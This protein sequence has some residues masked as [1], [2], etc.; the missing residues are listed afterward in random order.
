MYE[1]HLILLIYFRLTLF[2]LFV[3]SL[4]FLAKYIL[5]L[6][7]QK[8]ADRAW[9]QFENARLIFHEPS[10][11]RAYFVPLNHAEAI[12]HTYTRENPRDKIRWERWQITCEELEKLGFDIEE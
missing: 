4:F 5:I 11:H 1:N 9:E 6:D 12:L 2:I 3:I 10:L 8:E 7:W